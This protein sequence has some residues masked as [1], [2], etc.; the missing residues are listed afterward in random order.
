MEG[1]YKM[2]FGDESTPSYRASGTEDMYDSSYYFTEGLFQDVEQG[3]LVK[4]GSNGMFSAYKMF[5]DSIMPRH[6]SR[7]RLS[8]TNGDSGFQEP[9]YNVTS[10]FVVLYYT[11]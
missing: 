2:Y 6:S 1:D 3:V 5:W 10:S 7:F 8:W 11:K 9:G 4:D